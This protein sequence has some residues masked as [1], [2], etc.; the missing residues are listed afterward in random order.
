MEKLFVLTFVGARAIAIPLY[1]QTSCHSF[2][3][4]GSV[5][6]GGTPSSPGGAAGSVSDGWE[7]GH[8]WNARPNPDS[9]LNVGWLDA[10]KAGMG[11]TDGTAGGTGR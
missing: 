5:G 11:N 9:R 8:E 7:Y 10:G 4:S 3:T 2:G 6:S 1:A